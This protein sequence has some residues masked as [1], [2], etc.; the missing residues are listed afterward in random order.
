VA[1]RDEVIPW[2]MQRIAIVAPGGGATRAVLVALARA[3]AVELDAG[4]AANPGPV[5][6]AG[7]AV[8]K[9]LKASGG[10]SPDPV[11]QEA[12]PDVAELVRGGC[13]AE[14][15]GEAEIERV[16]ATMTSHGPVAAIAGWCPRGRLAQATADLAAAGGA[17][18]RVAPRPNALAPT[19]F[20]RAGLSGAFQ[21]LVDTYGTVPYR[22]LNPSAIAGL[23]YVAMFGMMFGDVG[24]GSL[25]LLLGVLVWSGRPRQLASLRRFGP[26]LVGAGITSSLFGLA[27]GEFF[28][29][30]QVVPVLWLR[31]LDHAGTL[32]ALSI[33]V[34]G[35]FIAVSYL[36]GTVNRWRESGPAAALVDGSGMAGAIV[37][38]G[39]VLGAAGFYWHHTLLVWTGVTALS[40]GLV[41]GFVG[42]LGRAGPGR[43]HVVQAIV[44]LFDSTLRIG[45]NT[46]SF[47]RLAAFGLT[48]AAL[49]LVIWSG[50]VALASKGPVGLIPASLLF[51]AGNAAAFA[52]EGLVA[53]VQALRLEY[54]EMFSRIFIGEGRPFRPWHIP[55]N[56][57]EPQEVQCSP[58]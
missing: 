57:E 49:G 3:G 41:L 14:L 17:L 32:I 52:L 47:A 18:V 31:P 50:T 56:T 15:L 1:W 2:A 37:Y 7:D 10:W 36:L 43:G 28:G 23:A 4:V 55:V 8:E 11:I 44:E 6:P 53:G 39:L 46:V 19:T 42:C 16:A 13:V 48:H 25:L 30:T 45:S 58:G 20:G 38:A 54:Y 5:G 35:V 29:P 27:Y 40:V 12:T 51:L 26:F 9:T 34:G 22:D 33:G 21:P 24:H